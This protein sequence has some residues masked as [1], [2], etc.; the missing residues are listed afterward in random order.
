MFL[1]QWTGGMSPP[2][3]LIPQEK[4][5]EKLNV[6][7]SLLDART[8]VPNNV[9]ISGFGSLDKKIS[10]KGILPF[11]I[12]MGGEPN[13]EFSNFKG[14]GRQG[15]RKFFF[16]SAFLKPDP[17]SALLEPKVLKVPA[18]V[19]GV[20]IIMDSELES[21]AIV[22]GGQENSLFGKDGCPLPLCAPDIG[23]KIP[24]LNTERGTCLCFV[25]PI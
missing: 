6:H 16:F 19:T 9:D 23:D 18:L 2:P 13:R 22:Q 20:L 7:A 3:P 24:W 12:S 8:A 17:Q 1:V 5:N 4:K 15:R 21:I 10:L 14:A 25:C 11:S